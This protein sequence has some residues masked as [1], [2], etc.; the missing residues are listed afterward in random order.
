MKREN[1]SGREENSA[2][3]ALAELRNLESGRIADE[4]R[5]RSE[6]AQAR[7]L[8]AMEAE[9]RAREAAEQ[10]ARAE[11]EAQA[12]AQAEAERLAREEQTRLYEVE[13]R[14][15]IEHESRLRGEQAR[16][17]AQMRLA[18]RAAAPRWPFIAVPLLVATV[19]IAGTLAFRGAQE[20]ERQ[21]D[22]IEQDRQQQVDQLAAITSKLDALEDEQVR[23]EQERS[24]LV[25]QLNAA[26]TE[27]ERA[28]LKAKQDELE[29][30]LA[31]NAD[32]RSTKPTPH[33]STT[34]KKPP[35]AKIEV[36]DS[37]DPLPQRRD[38]I[39]IDDS[40]DPLAGLGAP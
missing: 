11:Q 39:V 19:A 8:A 25:V 15:R 34:T 5:R 33:K 35:R 14:A 37:D 17:E 3:L 10:A 29:R 2:L 36:D 21:A 4:Q 16:M 9:R 7:H 28:E 30:Q 32:A 31:A 13:M 26:T 38:K 18:E 22:L 23:L 6:E 1:S 24:E 20:A 27:A 40:D 12:R